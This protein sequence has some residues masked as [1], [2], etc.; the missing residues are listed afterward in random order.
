MWG[1]G[2]RMESKEIGSLVLDIY[3]EMFMKDLSGDIKLVM[4]IY[5]FG[6]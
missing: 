6:F 3:F 5:K 2:V 1:I 4:K